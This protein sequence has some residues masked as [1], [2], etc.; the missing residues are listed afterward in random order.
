M[1]AQSPLNSDPSFQSQA[2]PSGATETN[3][4]SITDAAEPDFIPSEPQRPKQFVYAQ[5]D[6]QALRKALDESNL[7][8][9]AFYF[10]DYILRAQ[11][12][13]FE[14]IYKQQEL[15]RIVSSMAI[16]TVLLSGMYGLTMGMYDGA[17][18]AIAAAIKLPLLFLMTA[19]ICI[20]SLYTFNVLLGQRFRFMQTVALMSTTLCTT[21]I[22]LASLAPIAF[23]F[24]VTTN[25]YQF[26]LLMHVTIFGLCGSYGVRYLYRGCTYVA[27]RMEQA[28]NRPLLR[29]WI[30]IYAI[31]GMQLGWRLRPFLGS[32]GQP[33][34]LFRSEVGGNFYIAVWNSIMSFFH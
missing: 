3:F 28:L 9:L 12:A 13:L 26:L 14:Q 30:I 18:Q 25:H 22:L 15:T 8:R 6:I 5:Q 19:C 23:F 20:P 7:I 29:I 33:F 27:F 4:V 21:A 2:D 31:V 17:P 10:L 1:E 11:N 32:E 24:G 34:Q 16:L